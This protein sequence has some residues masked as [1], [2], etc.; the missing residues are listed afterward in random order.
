VQGRRETPSEYFQKTSDAPLAKNA[1]GYQYTLIPVSLKICKNCLK[2][3]LLS[4]ETVNTNPGKKEVDVH[5]LLNGN[6]ISVAKLLGRRTACNSAPLR[7]C[8]TAE[9]QIP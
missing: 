3:D 6:R 5:L 4:G 1:Y 9:D 7:L 2:T 8:T